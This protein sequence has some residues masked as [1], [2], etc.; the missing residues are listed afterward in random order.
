[1]TVLFVL[2]VLL[3]T[4]FVE[5][6]VT[7]T[8]PDAVLE[9]LE[10]LKE[11]VFDYKI[12]R[13][14]ETSLAYFLPLMRKMNSLLLRGTFN[15]TIQAVKQAA[16]NIAKADASAIEIL[17]VEKQNSCIKSLSV[18]INL[19]TEMSGFYSSDCLNIYNWNIFNITED[20]LTDMEMSGMDVDSFPLILINAFIG[21]NAFTQ[22]DDIIGRIQETYDSSMATYLETYSRLMTKVNQFA[23]GWH[24]EAFAIEN[25]LKELQT[26]LASSFSEIT[27]QIPVCRKYSGK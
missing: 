18:Q 15:Y 3:V 7:V 22:P 24:Q 17:A 14:G 25:C 4:T 26:D 16:A 27:T 12:Y 5:S 6:Q 1:M 2:A 23:L 11:L 8:R 20:W 9:K 10:E 21:R 19:Q 13:D